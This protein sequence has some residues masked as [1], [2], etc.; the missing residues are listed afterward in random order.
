MLSALHTRR[1]R[2]GAADER[3][4]VTKN[5]KPERREWEGVSAVKIKCGP[6][7]RSLMPEKVRGALGVVRVRRSIPRRLEGGRLARRR[8]G[9]KEVVDM[10]CC[11]KGLE[12][13]AICCW[14]QSISKINGEVGVVVGGD[15]HLWVEVQ[16]GLTDNYPPG[17]I[18]GSSTENCGSRYS[19][20]VYVL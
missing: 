8:V 9:D 17:V 11:W 18:V 19:F 3:R 12:R 20:I 13:T 4:G 15:F 6:A 10:T 5:Q 7:G 2:G 16:E 14:L 1:T